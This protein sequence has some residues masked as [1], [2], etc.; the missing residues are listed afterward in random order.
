VENDVSQC[1]GATRDVP[2][3]HALPP[4][5]VPQT[6]A[7]C[8]SAMAR[9]RDGGCAAWPSGAS[10]SDLAAWIGSLIADIH[11]AATRVEGADVGTAL[12][13]DADLDG[14][15][16]IVR[17]SG[18]P[19]SI[20]IRGILQANLILFEELSQGGTSLAGDKLDQIDR[21]FAAVLSFLSAS[22]S[23]PARR[24]GAW[25]SAPVKGYDPLRRWVRGHHIFV[26]LTQGLILSL[27]DIEG[28]LNE[29][30]TDDVAAA[31]ELATVL[32]EGSAIAFQFA[33]DFAPAQYRD[34]VRPTMM[35]PL[36]PEGL[37]GVLSADHRY[38]QQVL[39]RLKPRL[40]QVQLVEA[41]RYR[42]FVA[43]FQQAYDDHIHVCSRFV[44]SR[45]PSLLMKPGDDKS[46]VQQLEHFKRLRMKVFKKSSG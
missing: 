33:A 27:Q 45:E 24:I 46:A 17:V 3:V 39:N 19:A 23:A 29:G 28:A 9:L 31:L 16:R 30:R 14:Y 25:N 26:M 4:E 40:K 5:L 43:A 36:A 32:M 8:A 13:G 11:V 37:S 10:V 1:G 2:V 44:G 7:L 21:A 12:A 6:R 42:R 38:L 35:P 15:C 20:F 41:D 18:E 34:T 22:G